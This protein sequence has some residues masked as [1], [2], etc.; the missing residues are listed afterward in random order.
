MYAIEIKI[1][2]PFQ[3]T[4]VVGQGVRIHLIINNE[5]TLI[6][7]IEFFFNCNGIVQNIIQAV[8][9][10]NIKEKKDS[11]KKTSKIN[12]YC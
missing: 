11:N 8:C 5:I 3:I 2:I 9:T 7:V 1:L 4:A 10:L 12:Y 6:S